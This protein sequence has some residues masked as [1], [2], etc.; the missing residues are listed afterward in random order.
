MIKQ[1]SYLNIKGIAICL[2]IGLMMLNGCATQSE[3]QKNTISDS[4]QVIREEIIA[5]AMWLIDKDYRFGGS[6]PE[7]GFDCSGLVSHV[8]MK[9]AGIR[10]PHNAAM[11][12]KEGKAIDRAQLKIGDLVFFNINKKSYAHVGIFIGNDR[13][14][15][16][17]NR[18][19]KIKISSLKS[20]FYQANFQTARSLL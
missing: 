9:V 12:A 8:Y 19:S 18:L 7:T 15:H 2:M 20:G 16:A 11:M 14:I 3:I 6:D 17:P 5:H 13:F 10:L 1:A 4:N